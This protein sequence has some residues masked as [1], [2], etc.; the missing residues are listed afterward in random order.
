MPKRVD[1]STRHAIIALKKKNPSWNRNKVSKKLK[2]SWDTANRWWG[3]DSIKEKGRRTKQL[4]EGQK[5]FIIKNL[6]SGES[7]RSCAKKF[8][9]KFNFSISY[10]KVY[11]IARKSKQNTGGLYPYK[12]QLKCSLSEKQVQQRRNYM[13]KFPHV[14][15]SFK[16]FIQKRIIYDEK[17]FQ[18]GKPPNKQN[19][20]YWNENNDI[21][22]RIY[23]SKKSPTTIEV[24]AAISYFGKSNIR[25]YIEENTYKR[26]V[27]RGKLYISIS[28]ELLQ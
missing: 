1:K 22:N 5:S 17:P 19:N 23:S 12:L 7:L 4:T 27:N 28:S 26:G 11:S 3:E 24:F 10:Q 15:D 8:G 13:F 21:Q 18:L 25:F 6:K 2:I 9:Q 20:R 14:Q 16:R